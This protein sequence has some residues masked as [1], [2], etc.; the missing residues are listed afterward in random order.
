ML[1]C[2]AVTRPLCCLDTLPDKICDDTVPKLQGGLGQIQCA[3][4]RCSVSVAYGYVRLDCNRMMSTCQVS[5][6]QRQ[7]VQGSALPVSRKIYCLHCRA[8][9]AAY[10]IPAVSNN[11][12]L[13]WRRISNVLIPA[14]KCGSTR[15]L[16]RYMRS[17]YWL[18]IGHRIAATTR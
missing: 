12:S 13:R 18:K 9:A 16:R 10:D 15:M 14:T 17:C 1:N 4:P 3:M 5:S 2:K 8:L 7:P 6:G 11:A